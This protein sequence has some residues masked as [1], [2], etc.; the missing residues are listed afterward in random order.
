[1]AR[2]I[3]PDLAERAARVLQPWSGAA[4][5]ERREATLLLR[6]YER[7]RVD[8]RVLAIRDELPVEEDPLEGSGSG[9]L[10]AAAETPSGYFGIVRPRDL[11]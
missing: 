11:P 9:S 4:A 10:T 5:A 2:F 7:Q 8:A 1:L 6:E 3:P